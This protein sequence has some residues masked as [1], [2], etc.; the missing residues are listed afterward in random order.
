[1]LCKLDVQSWSS[2]WV[3]AIGKWQRPRVWIRSPCWSVPHEE[4][5]GLM[6][7]LGKHPHLRDKEENGLTKDPD[8]QGSERQTARAMVQGDFRGM[9]V[10]RCCLSLKKFK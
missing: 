8:K 10:F 5:R 6:P 9:G 3:L 7:Y 4:N 1:M 2:A